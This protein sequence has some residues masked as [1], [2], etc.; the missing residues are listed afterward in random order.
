[1]AAPAAELGVR[2]HIMP[3]SADL[4]LEVGMRTGVATGASKSVAV[5]VIGLFTLLCGGGYA[6]FGGYLIFA[7]VGWFGRPD[8]DPLKQMMAPLVFL[9]APFL[10]G[11]GVLFVLLGVLVLLAALG[12]LGRKQWGRSLTFLVAVLAI[13]LGLLWLSGVEDVLQ[14]AIDL[15][16]GVTQVLYGILALVILSMK[17]TEFSKPR[18]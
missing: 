10:V 4:S 8:A 2:Q 16:L 1:V 9:A 18:A 17:G 3:D 13:L 5:T 14:D 15:A 12:V 6:I 11:V 7:V